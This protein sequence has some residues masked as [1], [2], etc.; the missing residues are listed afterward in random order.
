[1][2]NSTY[3]PAVE[4]GEIGSNAILHVRRC[5]VTESNSSKFFAVLIEVEV[6][7]R[8][9]PKMGNPIKWEPGMTYTP[10]AA[11]GNANGSAAHNNNNNKPTSSMPSN[12]SAKPAP[13]SRP[14]LN[15]S[16][17][18]Q[19][20]VHPISGLNPYQNKWAI[21]GRVISKGDKRSWSNSRGEGTLF[22]FEV[23]DESGSLKVT[24]FKEECEKFY[25]V[26]EEGKVYLI[27]KGAL[28]PKDAR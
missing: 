18:T 17:T 3:N 16:A 2:L 13:P 11:K 6:V 9:S 22:S 15:T 24:A 10:P 1:M 8:D 23:Q 12:G 5:N 21:K 26:I 27:T 25:N 7:A 19:A 4:S 14:N 28:K 20:N